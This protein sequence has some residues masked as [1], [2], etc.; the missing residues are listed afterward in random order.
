MFFFLFLVLPVL[1]IW[2]LFKVGSVIGGF[3]VFASLLVL[4]FVGL[5]IV[6][7]EAKR[8]VLDFQQALL[9]QS[10]PSLKTVQGMMTVVAGVLLMIPGFIT[11]VVALSL[12]F[13]GTRQLLSWVL[14]KWLTAK[15]RSGGLRFS[16]NGFKFAFRSS[17][18]DPFMYGERFN[19]QDQKTGE[20]YSDVIEVKARPVIDEKLLE[21]LNSGLD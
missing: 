19:R 5:Q 1:E 10:K 21:N 8:V 17:R 3:R 11:D 9:Q 6:K 13:P 2:L 20:P 15:L 7:F 16:D 4:F 14:Q 12:L 18:V